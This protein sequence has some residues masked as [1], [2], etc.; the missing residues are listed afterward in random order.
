MK[1]VVV[2]N[3]ETKACAGIV[4]DDEA[5]YRLIEKRRKLYP[6]DKN[7]EFELMHGNAPCPA[8]T[9]RD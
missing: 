5:A 6:Q 9:D 8:F 7:A 2:V 1:F 3:K 4:R